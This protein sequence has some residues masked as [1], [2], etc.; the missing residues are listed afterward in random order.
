MILQRRKQ[1]L[2]PR[3]PPRSRALMAHTRVVSAKQRLVRGLLDHTGDA[4]MLSRP[5]R[6]VDV[7]F[8]GPFTTSESHRRRVRV[9]APRLPHGASSPTA[10]SPDRQLSKRRPVTAR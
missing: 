3:T 6:E 5:A 7:R 4:T 8:R 1:R 9:Y 10:A 2:C